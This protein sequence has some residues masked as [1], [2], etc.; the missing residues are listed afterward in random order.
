MKSFIINY[1]TLAEAKRR[2]KKK[3][4]KER[5]RE[6]YKRNGWLSSFGVFFMTHILQRV[7]STST[8]L[9]S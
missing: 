4:K 6:S 7:Y 3:N 2:K 1:C 5:E 9:K 8:E